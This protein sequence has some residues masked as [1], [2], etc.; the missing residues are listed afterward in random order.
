MLTYVC[1]DYYKARLLSDEAVSLARKI[2]DTRLDLTRLR[3]T[4]PQ[5]RLT[6]HSANDKLDAQVKDMQALGD[7][8]EALNENL[9]L[10]KEKVREGAKDLERLRIERAE[11]EKVKVER[12][13]VEDERVL[14]LY[15][16]YV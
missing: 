4:F 12:T 13:E 14:G 1:A 7:E 9:D 6:I 3:Q 8:L 2:L 10:V 5:P 11:M 16:W 15:D